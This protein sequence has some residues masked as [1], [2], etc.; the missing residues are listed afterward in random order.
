MKA[1]LENRTGSRFCVITHDDTVQDFCVNSQIPVFNLREFRNLLIGRKLKWIN[2]DLGICCNFELL[3]EEVF[4]LPKFGSVNIHPASL[5]HFGG[6]YPFPMLVESGQSYSEVCIHKI[7]A[8]PDGGRVILRRPY[9]I[10][11]S[12]YYLDW[13]ATVSKVSI[14]LILDFL[15]LDIY[16][17]LADK[18]AQSEELHQD[19]LHESRTPRRELISDSNLSLYDAVRINSLVGGTHLLNDRGEIITIF[20]AENLNQESPRVNSYQVTEIFK[21][22]FILSSE[23]RKIINVVNWN[24]KISKGDFLFRLKPTQ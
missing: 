2:F 12:D 9:P 21:E 23:N 5:P 10:S 4:N 22:S 3:P 14:N 7:T 18:N 17:H 20:I 16:M 24:G 1:I 8:R 19:L 13:L 15:N 11:L 6:R